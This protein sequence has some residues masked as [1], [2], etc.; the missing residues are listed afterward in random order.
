MIPTHAAA[1]VVQTPYVLSD[2]R[3]ALLNYAARCLM[4]GL[5]SRSPSV[6]F[7]YLE[8]RYRARLAIMGSTGRAFR[9]EVFDGTGCTLV[10]RSRGRYLDSWR[11]RV[12]GPCATP[13]DVAQARAF[14][15][16]IPNGAALQALLSH[17]A[18]QMFQRRLVGWSGRVYF[19][20]DAD[21]ELSD[22]LD[23]ELLVEGLNS[24]GR[25]VAQLVV[26]QADETLCLRVSLA[27]GSWM[28]CEGIPQVLDILD[29]SVDPKPLSSPPSALL[30]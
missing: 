6:E 14:A 24:T 21:S 15:H 5:E 7:A 2:G 8:Q 27:V 3:Q 1:S 11:P 22:A 23:G 9:L 20:G 16:G 19:N 13:E 26:N 17:A 25:F 29:V 30:T 10:C 4:R 18:G 28:V 12:G